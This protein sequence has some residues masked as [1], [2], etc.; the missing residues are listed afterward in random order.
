MPHERRKG[1]PEKNRFYSSESK[2][3]RSINGLSLH[4]TS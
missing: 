2:L 3:L 4:F 1:D